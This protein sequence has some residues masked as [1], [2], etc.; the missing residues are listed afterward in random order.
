MAEGLM[1]LITSGSAFKIHLKRLIKNYPKVAFGVA[2]ASAGT[3]P[4]ALLMKH[5]AKIR[6][7]IFGIHF[8]QTHPD[9]LDAFIDAATVKFVLQPQGVLHPTVYLFWDDDR[10]EAIIGSANFTLGAMTNNTVL[11]TLLSHE[12]REFLGEVQALL[13]I[14]SNGAKS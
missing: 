3:E 12:D 2:W 5:K 10:W 7:G 13:E 6:A 1:E 11:G 4:F 9:V 14:Y 8:Y